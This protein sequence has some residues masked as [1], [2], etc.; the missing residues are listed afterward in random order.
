MNEPIVSICCMTKDLEGY[1]ADGIKSFL[2]QQ[3]AY[4][5]EIVLSDDFSKDN[6][7]AVC[8]SF[9]QEHPDKIRLL[10]S[11][12]KLGLQ[13][14]FIKSMQACKGKYIAFCD[15]DDYWTDPLKLQKQITYLEQNPGCNLVCSD[16]DYLSEKGEFIESEWKADWYGQ[17]FDIIENTRHA[18]ATT[19]TTII[20]KSSLDPL[21]SNI[22]MDK[23][24]FIWD[25]VLWAYCLKEGYGYF[26]PGK[27]A[28]RRVRF[29]GEYTTKSIIDRAY[30]DI[31]SFK[32]IKELI[33]DKRVQ[34]SMNELLYEV[35]LNVSREYIK[36]GNAKRAKNNLLQSALHWNGLADL[37]NNLRYVYWAFKLTLGAKLNA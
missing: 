16:Y 3:T 13:K 25:T 22:T 24:P 6:T 4:T 2:A 10:T 17:K 5:F 37:K 32:A 28:L 35:N 11:N 8:R 1:I 18:V 12:K 14:N 31:N 33:K 27:M 29:E 36:R 30:Y 21:L 34:E 23:H 20:R 7:V 19:L 26:H 15:G 9:Q